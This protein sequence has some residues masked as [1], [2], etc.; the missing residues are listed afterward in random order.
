M[1]DLRDRLAALPDDQ[2]LDILR[3][4][5]A[6]TYRAEV[7]PIVEALLRERGIDPRT[8]EEEGGAATEDGAEHT[9]PDLALVS[10]FESVFEAE[11][12][13]SAL[14]SAGIR[15]W[16]STD[17]AIGAL[18]PL[19]RGEGIGILVRTDEV[20]AAQ[21]IVQDLTQG[22]AALDEDADVGEPEEFD[23]AADEDE[24][25]DDER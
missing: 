4:R 3:E 17:P 18:A 21:E 6:D 15:A 1:S 10:N 7:F 13:R 12:C 11:F 16:L 19:R 20:E 23:D 2:L 8:A 22:G 14:L 24:G 25:G 9:I 5:D